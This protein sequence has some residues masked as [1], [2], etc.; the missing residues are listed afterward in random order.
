MERGFLTAQQ[1][2]DCLDAQRTSGD[3]V[4]LGLVMLRQAGVRVASVTGRSSSIVEQR[5]RE[6]GIETVLQGVA[7]KAA[8]PM[9]TNSGMPIRASA[10]RRAGVTKLLPG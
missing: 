1:L 8:A 3:G 6:L 7:D 2:S 9:T 5:A 10:I 4:M